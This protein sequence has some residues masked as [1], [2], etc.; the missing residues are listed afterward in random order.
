MKKLILLI[1][2][3]VLFTGNASA[4]IEG[5]LSLEYDSLN[6][7]NYGTFNLYKNFN[8]KFKIGGEIQKYNNES[9][10]ENIKLLID[11]NLT[12][13][14]EINFEKGNNR[15]FR[16]PNYPRKYDDD[17][18][19]FGLKYHLLK[20]NNSIE[21]Y[22]SLKYEPESQKSYGEIYVMKNLTK[23][24]KIGGRMVTDMYDWG[25]KDG[26]FPAGHP[27]RQTYDLIIEYDVTD[28][29]TINLTE[30]C[31]HY[32]SQSNYNSVLDD[33]YLRYGITYNF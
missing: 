25:L 17:Y 19:R 5:S 21:S 7:N 27:E 4:E 15:Y 11:L 18:I 20:N 12:D 16:E 14:I 31:R 2:F 10:E 3:I 8:D 33:W 26:W 30:G 22:V 9:N 13:K 24:F 23:K 1:L 28:N 32:F 29:I 6:S